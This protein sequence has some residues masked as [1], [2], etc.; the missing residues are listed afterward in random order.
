MKTLEI[1]H[2][3]RCEQN[4]NA[5]ADAGFFLAAAEIGSSS[6]SSHG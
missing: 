5:R 3:Y 2:F 4:V 1:R 6:A